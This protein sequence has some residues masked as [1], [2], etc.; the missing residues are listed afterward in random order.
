MEKDYVYYDLTTMLNQEKIKELEDNFSLGLMRNESI[1]N[2]ILIMGNIENDEE[3]ELCLLSDNLTESFCNVLRHIDIERFDIESL[4][5]CIK[6]NKSICKE[7]LEGYAYAK[8]EDAASS[9][10]ELS[11]NEDLVKRTKF[12]KE[13][14]KILRKADDNAFINLVEELSNDTDFL[15]QS[16]FVK[17][18]N[19][20]L[21]VFNKILENESSLSYDQMMNICE[22]LYDGDVLDVRNPSYWDFIYNLISKENNSRLIE[23]EKELL[24]A[25]PLIDSSNK[26]KIEDSSLFL[27]N[28]IK[29]GIALSNLKLLHIRKPKDVIDLSYSLVSLAVSP[30]ICAL[31]NQRY[32]FILSHVQ[33]ND[34]RREMFSLIDKCEMLTLEKENELFLESTTDIIARVKKLEMKRK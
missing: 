32:N 8:N 4:F 17:R 19:E 27:S 11:K 12:F 2:T 5:M 16:S 10:V 3:I 6:Q 30:Y 31:D 34:L 20:M 14:I 15:L 28:D 1:K 26:K 23:S 22:I 29:I 21:K 9:I 24:V 33:N 18:S 13:I 25:Y 7:I